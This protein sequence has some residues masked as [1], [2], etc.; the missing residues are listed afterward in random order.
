M[1]FKCFWEGYFF[2]I[3]ARAFVILMVLNMTLVIRDGF[4]GDVIY[5]GQFFATFLGVML[6]IPGRIFAVLVVRGWI[7]AI[8]DLVFVCAG[9]F[10]QDFYVFVCLFCDFGQGF[11]DTGGVVVGWNFVIPNRIFSDVGDSGQDFL[12]F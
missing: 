9:G 8:W 7:S 10:C 11:C 6:V 4:V 1:F 5:F 12:C 3:P 2:E